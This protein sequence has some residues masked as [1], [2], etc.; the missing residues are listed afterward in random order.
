MLNKEDAGIVRALAGRFYWLGLLG[1]VVTLGCALLAASVFEDSRGRGYSPLVHWISDLG[2]HGIS[3]WASI[4]NAGM[5][6]GAFMLGSFTVWTCLLL[7][8]KVGYAVAFMGV[9]ATVGMAFVGVFPDGGGTPLYHDMS[10]AAGFIGISGLGASF[11]LFVLIVEQDLL[12]KW[13]FFPSLLSS[14]CSGIFVA[15]VTANRTG[16]VSWSS[17]QWIATDGR[18]VVRLIPLF[19]WLGFLSVFLWSFLAAWTLRARRLTF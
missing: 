14:V 5:I 9:V 18:P 11:C 13:L 1:P 2:H 8:S 17:L 16:L 7:R 6:T 12:P 3:P 4:F 15:L 10:G 19:E